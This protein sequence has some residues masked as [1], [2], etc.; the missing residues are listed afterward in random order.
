VRE[1]TILLPGSAGAYVPDP[2]GAA[3]PGDLTNE[4]I[5]TDWW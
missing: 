2:S 5:E 1:E 3:Q 4:L